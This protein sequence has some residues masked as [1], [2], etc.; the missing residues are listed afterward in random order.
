MYTVSLV[1]TLSPSLLNEFRGGYRKSSYIGW[2]SFERPD[3][4]GREAAQYVPSTNGLPYVPKSILFPEHFLPFNFSST[5][6]SASPVFDY[7]DTLSWSRGK[8][9]L[10]FG[11]E[12]RYQNSNGWNS[13]Y[14]IPYVNLGAGAFPVTGLDSASVPGL[15]AQNQTVAQQILLDLSGSV[16][17]TREGFSISGSSDPVFLDYRDQKQKRRDYHQRDWTAFVKD[18]WKLRPSLTLNV[19]LR[20]EFFGVPWEARG[21]MAAAVGGNAGLYG[22]SGGS[23]TAVQFVGKNSPNPD[24][25]VHKDDWNN[26]GPAVGLSWQ[27]PWFGKGKTV[28]RAGYGINYNGAP[29]FNQLDTTV[30][31]AP[32]TNLIPTPM[33]STYTNL[34]TVANLLPVAKTAPLQP[35]P[36]NDRTQ[37]MYL[38][39]TDYVIPY[40]QNFNFE[41]QRELA[42]DW[43]LDLR[44][45]GT[46]GTRLYAGV[47]IN[48]VNIFDNGILEA[49][50][51]TRA[52]GIAP[53]FDKMLAG[54]N[55]PGAGVVNGTSLTGS[56][57]LRQNTTTRSFIAN[58]N[59]GALANYLNTTPSG[60]GSPGGLLRNAGLPNNFIVA[61]PQFLNVEMST[62]PGSSTYHSLV[63]QVTKRFSHGFTHQLAYTWSRSL[64]EFDSD[65]GRNTTDFSIFRVID[66]RNRRENKTLINHRTHDIRSNGTWQLPF[67]PQRKLL[68]NSNG[69][70]ARL[71]E[72]WQLG[73]IFSWNS[74]A[75]LTLLSSR[76]T[77]TSRTT[78]T[79][80][81][82]ATFPKS[83]GGVTRVANGVTYFA[84][85]TQVTD[86]DR[87][88]VTTAQ[89]AQGSYSGTAIADAQGRILLT[90]APPGRHGNMGLNWIEG[91]ANLGLDMNL[92]KRIK[93]AE[94]K[95][96]EF[97]LDA[98]SILNHPNFGNPVLNIN[99]NTF[100]R[101][102]T[103]TGN[104]TFVANLRLNF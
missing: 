44:Y 63:T 22:I 57:A 7:V 49:F 51:V 77:I 86:P 73:A 53:L 85:L 21:L 102:T 12:I 72:R 96:F 1:S 88:N 18:D 94:T 99:M 35:I 47:S 19:G 98:L 26:F 82:V 87:A 103:A 75:P 41:L 37:N 92:I 17:S 42:N 64:G 29:R 11:G 16:D 79:P 31:I 66:P 14:L 40:I 23:L 36:L 101:I 70:V 43:S 62:N 15:V 9:A 4:A 6:E 60:T 81:I 33:P 76:S 78:I 84:G 10:K 3:S 90:N 69:I 68:G 8:H 61:N 97:R 5:R 80:D 89:S 50:N 74:G 20:Y 38:F 65:G 39:D 95:E 71:V 58:G 32:G 56:A 27:L 46:K 83:T 104:R 2:G 24:L 54:V 45:V 100:G 55:F 52:G 13:E 67:G 30:G 34:A 59:V 25:K 28:L 48:E 93:I 91:P